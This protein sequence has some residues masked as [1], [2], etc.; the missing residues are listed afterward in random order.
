MH[1][2]T[3]RGYDVKVVPQY[4]RDAVLAEYIASHVGYPHSDG[5]IFAGLG[6]VAGAAEALVERGIPCVATGAYPLALPVPLVACDQEPGIAAA[7]AALLAAGHRRIAFFAFAPDFATGACWVPRHR[8]YVA[9]MERAGLLD[10]A[11]VFLTP[12][13]AEL[14]GLL[15]DASPRLPFTAAFCTNDTQAARLVRELGYLGTRVPGEV[16]VVGFDNHPLY[17]HGEQALSSVELPLYRMGRAAMARLAAMIDGEREPPMLE[18]IPSSF[19]PRRT[20]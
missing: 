5:V 8:A 12:G 2:A 18:L 11:L 7:L 15:R 19:V 9:A 14:R 4:N 17:Q 3:A 20:S 6:T 13:E 16:A 10:P 1:E